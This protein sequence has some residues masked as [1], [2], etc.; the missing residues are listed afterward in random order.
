MVD[1][2]LGDERLFLVFQCY[3]NRDLRCVE[4]SAGGIIGPED[5]V[6]IVE[7]I[8]PEAAEDIGA[9]FGAGFTQID[10][11]RTIRQNPCDQKRWS[12]QVLAR[13]DLDDLMICLLYTYPS[14]RD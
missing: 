6:R 12:M 3:P 4:D 10:P 14:P 5:L 1:D 7:W 11:A 8:E 9:A 2:R 13:P